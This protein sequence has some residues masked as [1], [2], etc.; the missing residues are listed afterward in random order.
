MSNDPCN[1]NYKPPTATPWT[2]PPPPPPP[3]PRPEP[4]RD[5]SNPLYPGPMRQLPEAPDVGPSKP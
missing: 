5:G 3:P 4:K 2:P 1:P